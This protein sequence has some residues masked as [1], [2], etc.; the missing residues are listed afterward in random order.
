MVHFIS[1]LAL[2]IRGGFGFFEALPRLCMKKGG[3]K[4]RKWATLRHSLFS[5]KVATSLSLNAYHR[6]L[7]S[8]A[9][10]KIGL[11]NLFRSFS[12]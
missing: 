12:G 10:R 4:Q 7:R 6:T 8:V 9:T 11:A 2:D 5:V 1:I 3:L